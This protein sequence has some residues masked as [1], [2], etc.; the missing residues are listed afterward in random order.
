MDQV[1]YKS[2]NLINVVID[3]INRYFDKPNS[4]VFS[5]LLIG[6]SIPDGVYIVKLIVTRHLPRRLLNGFRPNPIVGYLCYR[7]GKKSTQTRRI[8]RL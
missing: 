7:N 8:N 3:L 2:N 4:P 1:N 5:D 6:V